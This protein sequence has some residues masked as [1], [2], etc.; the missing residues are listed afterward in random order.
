MN[1]KI[2]MK[3]VAIRDLS[4]AAL[5]WASASC[6][7]QN[8]FCIQRPDLVVSGVVAPP[9]FSSDPVYGWPIIEREGI[10][11]RKIVTP[12]FSIHETRHY[13]ASKGDEIYRPDGYKRDMV[14]RPN[15]PHRLD[16][17]WL[18][19]MP[20]GTGAHD[21]WRKDHFLS[22]TSLVAAMRCWV[23]SKHGEFVEIPV[24][25]LT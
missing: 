20:I 2:A 23:A 16:G 22:P 25:L 4:G 9:P 3:R 15:P 1:S 21:L 13:D 5:D 18:A 7:E 17:W 6:E 11:T 14:R 10:S 24:Q 8:H 19:K 12:P